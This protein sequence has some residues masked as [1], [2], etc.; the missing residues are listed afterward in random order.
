M[1]PT[2]STQPSPQRSALM[3]RV[4]QRQTDI[5]NTVGAMLLSLGVQPQKNVRD[6]PGSPDF[7][8]HSRKVAI[9]VHGCFWHFHHQGS[10]PL[11]RVPKS[12][13]LFWHH[14]LRGNA[15][16]DGRK[17]KELRAIGWKVLTIWQCQ[18]ERRASSVRT[19]IEKAVGQAALNKLL[20]K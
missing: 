17:A 19:R 2:I 12:N 5:E 6:L 20:P 10:C 13:R 1:Q 3:K 18:L 8:L 11:S 14:K 7:A 4:R 9:F 15:A 16:R